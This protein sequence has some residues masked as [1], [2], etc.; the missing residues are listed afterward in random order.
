M[1]KGKEGT[2]GGSSSRQPPEEPKQ[3]WEI[4]EVIIQKNY[5]LHEADGAVYYSLATTR[6]DLPQTFWYSDW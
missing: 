2:G 4:N 5:T 6:T 3:L 1:G